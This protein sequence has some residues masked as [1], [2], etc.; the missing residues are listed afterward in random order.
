MLEQ[1]VQLCGHLPL[2]LSLL[3]A[4]L[5]HHPSWS[6]E[7]LRDRLLVAQDR[8]SELRAGDRAVTA[9]FDLSYRDLPPELQHFFRSL[10]FYPGTD[11]DAYVAAALGDVRQSHARRDLGEP[12]RRF[13]SMFDCEETGS[14]ETAYALSSGSRK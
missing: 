5:R 7:D 4:R 12:S 13:T 2:G 8:L 11:I 1:L 3:A 14:C 9:T 6:A 10:G